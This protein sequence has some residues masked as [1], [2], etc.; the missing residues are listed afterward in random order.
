VPFVTIL[1]NNDVTGNVI[2]KFCYNNN[3][4]NNN[5]GRNKRLKFCNFSLFTQN[6]YKI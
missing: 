4:N 2:K 3:N 6:V 1:E 5:N